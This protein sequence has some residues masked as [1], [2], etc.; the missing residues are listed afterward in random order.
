MAENHKEKYRPDNIII[1]SR[2]R[3]TSGSS[4]DSCDSPHHVDPSYRPK[5]LK[6]SGHSFDIVTSPSAEDP[7]ES[8]SRILVLYCGGTIGMRSHG[9]GK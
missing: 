2:S 6:K 9:G 5:I 7:Y 1:P 3:V 4:V 8:I